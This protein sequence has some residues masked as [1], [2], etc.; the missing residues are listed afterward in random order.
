MA[1]LTETEV[2]DDNPIA[3]LMDGS[4]TVA[5]KPAIYGVEVGD[6]AK[7]TSIVYQ[8]DIGTET[9]YIIIKVGG[10]SEV[11]TAEPTTLSGPNPA[12]PAGPTP[13]TP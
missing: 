7:V 3:R 12:P 11:T 4:V 5:G 10:S 6:K 2:T 9:H 1:D 8:I 13:G